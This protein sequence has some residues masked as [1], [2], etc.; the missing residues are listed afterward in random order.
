ME[1]DSPEQAL[2][3]ESRDTVTDTF[4]AK[5][6]DAK[7]NRERFAIAKSYSIEVTRITVLTCFFLL[8]YFYV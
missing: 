6:K 5:D 1:C 2:E 8:V 7:K 3:E 4:S